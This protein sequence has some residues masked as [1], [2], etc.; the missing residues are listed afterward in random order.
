MSKRIRR[1]DIELI[2][3]ELQAALKRETTDIIAIGDLLIEAQARLEHGQWLAW[4]EEHFGS[5]DRTAENYINA[6]RFAAKFET[7]SN[8]KLRPTAL[9]LLGRKLDELDDP[10]GFYNREVIKAILKAA[11]T[12][13]INLDRAVEIATS[14]QPLE[15]PIEESDAEMAGAEETAQSEID[16]ILEGPPPDLPPAPEATV[17]DVILLPFDQ[18]LATLAHLQTKPLTSFAASTHQLHKIKSVISFLQEVADAIERRKAAA[19][20]QAQDQ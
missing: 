16:D 6:A 11:E 8:L 2:A 13:W 19:Q 4:L 17:H 14:L 3:T 18:A 15:P 5:T 12:E 10:D 9:Y 1:R 20:P 7:V